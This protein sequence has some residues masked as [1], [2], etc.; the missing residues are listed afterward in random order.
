MMKTSS[1]WRSIQLSE[2]VADP[3]GDIVDGPFGS[4]LKAAEYVD[5]GVPIARLQNIDRNR[6]IEKNMKFVTPQKASEIA[7]HHFVAGDILISKLGDPLGEACI[8]PASVP[9]GILVADVVRV[10]PSRSRVDTSFLAYALNSSSVAAQ[11]K[12]ETKGTTRPR[13]N[14]TKI[15]TLQIPFVESLEEQRRISREID[16]QFTRLNVGATALSRVQANLKRY[17]AAVLGAACAGELVRTEVSTA[18]GKSQTSETGIELLARVLA[19]RRQQWTGRQAYGDPVGPSSPPPQCL[20]DGWAWAR[21][22]QLGST[23]GGLTK[24]PKRAKHQRRLPYLRVANVYANQ[25][26]LEEVKRIGVD[27]AE[28]S[29]LRLQ[30]ADLLIVE[31]NG[32]KDQIGRVAIWDGSIDPCVHQNHLIRFR[33]VLPILS[34]WILFWLLSPEGRRLIEVVTS[35][36]SGLYTLSVNKVSDLPIAVPPL[37]EQ[38]QIVAEVE[39]RLSIADELAAVIHVNLARAAAL[40]ASVL[41]RAFAS[42]L[43]TTEGQHSETSS[44]PTADRRP[45]RHFARALLSAEIVHQLHNQPT[46]GRVKHQKILHLCEHIAQIGEL[47][48]QYHREAAGPLDNKMIFANE[49]ELKKQKWYTTVA[50]K[51]YGH[52]YQPMLKAGGHRIYLERYWPEKIATIERLIELMRKWDTDACEILSTAY[53]AWNDLLIWRKEATDEAILNEILNRWNPEKRRFKIERWR[54]VIDWM[55]AEGFAP[56]GFGRPTSLPE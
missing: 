40:R 27:D 13:V 23:S 30:A 37:A 29:K 38:L 26:R 49:G 10:R 28:L 53:A 51:G 3:T 18:R 17:R 2:L 9:Y 24:N 43:V 8:A 56:S 31:G 41:R 22:G 39:R 1:S 45:N 47:E 16:E 15:R 32:S 4:R 54:R 20:P 36:T 14:L 33:P 46:F 5:T 34:K 19:E 35:S 11:F 12:A 7:R 6:F 48:G 50:R 44:H 52:A 55:K 21:L 42:D 25:L